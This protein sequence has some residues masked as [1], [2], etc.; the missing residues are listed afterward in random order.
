MAYFYQDDLLLPLPLFYPRWLIDGPSVL[1][2][3]WH[4]RI[5]NLNIDRSGIMP[6]EDRY[7][8]DKFVNRGEQVILNSTAKLARLHQELPPKEAILFAK[9]VELLASRL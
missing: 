9:S 5:D 8:R 7:I 2:E 1:T 4:I 3:R 6:R